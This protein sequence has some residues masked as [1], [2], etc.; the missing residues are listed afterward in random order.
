MMGLA[1][2]AAAPSFDDCGRSDAILLAEH[3]KT[4]EIQDCSFIYKKPQ[5]SLT[6]LY[7]SCDRRP[8]CSGGRKP[9]CCKSVCLSQYNKLN[10]LHV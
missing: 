7:E 8:D 1:V 3:Y 4:A 5:A 6:T 10:I 2:S 9:S